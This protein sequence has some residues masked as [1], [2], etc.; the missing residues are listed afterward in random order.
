MSYKA[1]DVAADSNPSRSSSIPQLQLQRNTSHFTPYHSISNTNTTS[2]ITMKFS[3]AISA[4][5]LGFA[6]L[7]SAISGA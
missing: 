4:A 7:S 1:D 2:T 3:S 6:S 5:A